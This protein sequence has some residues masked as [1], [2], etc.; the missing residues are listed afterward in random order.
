MRTIQNLRNVNPGFATDHILTFGLAPEHAGYPSNQ[1]VPV[2][3]RALEALAAL[4]GVRGA[5]ATNDAELED[6]NVTGDVTVAGYTAKPDAD[7]NVELPW[8]SD[9]Y[10]QTL[11]I[12]LVAGRYFSPADSATATRVL[13]VNETFAR[14][15]LAARKTR[16][17]IMSAVPNGRRRTQ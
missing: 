12:P 1:I 7:L 8:I 4:P 6:D 17:A 2:E 15:Y 9:N 14:H 10:L 11:G 13:I 5:G 16:S 3:Q